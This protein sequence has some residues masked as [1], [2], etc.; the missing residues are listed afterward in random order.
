MR[1]EAS[2]IRY[3]S[4]VNFFFLSAC[5]QHNGLFASC[6]DDS[7]WAVESYRVCQVATIFS[8]LVLLSKFVTY[9]AKH[10][11]VLR[12]LLLASSCSLPVIQSTAMDVLIEIGPYLIAPTSSA[13]SSPPSSPRCYSPR[14]YS[15]RSGYPP[16][17]CE[18]Q[19]P[20]E[21]L[22]RSMFESLMGQDRAIVL[23]SELAG[24]QTGKAVEASCTKCYVT[25]KGILFECHCQPYRA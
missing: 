10:D 12:F 24:F 1:R 11:D 3:P 19:H 23:K 6:C 8:N 22:V 18:A 16:S 21:L 4:C 15:P 17:P 14:P 7:T 9:L 20:L 5:H 25:L 13:S 2:R